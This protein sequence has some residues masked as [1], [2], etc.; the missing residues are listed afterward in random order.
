MAKRTGLTK[1]LVGLLTLSLMISLAVPALAADPAAPSAA[2][3]RQS[4]VVDGKDV[5]AEAYAI[6]GY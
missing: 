4:L 2:P 5:K 1:L 6:D 3:S